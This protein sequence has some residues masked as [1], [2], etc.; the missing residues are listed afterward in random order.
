MRR[1]AFSPRDKNV[2]A[3]GPGATVF[4]R[5]RPRAGM[6][7]DLSLRALALVAGGSALG[8]ALRYLA[9]VWLSRPGLPWGTLAV[10][11]VGSFAIGYLAFG[12]F[13]RGA[14]GDD[15]RLFLA[16]GLLGGFTTMS[17]FAAD[18]LL[19]AEEGA[20]LRAVGYAAVTVVG[21]LAACLLGR[22][23]AHAT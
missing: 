3:R 21:S 23:L 11:L 10:N 4:P 1:V 22:A 5:A 8:G 20:P 6:M 2:P 18:T 12:A 13:A 7:A 15:A 16:V 19:L 17:A 9:Q 14:L